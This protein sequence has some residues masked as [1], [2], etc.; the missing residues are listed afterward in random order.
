VL[1]SFG[2]FGRNAGSKSASRKKSSPRDRDRDRFDEHEH[3]ALHSADEYDDND[4]GGSRQ[5]PIGEFSAEGRTRSYSTL[6]PSYRSMTPDLHRASGP[7]PAM[8]RRMTLPSKTADHYASALFDFAG[9]AADELPLYEGQIVLVKTQ[10]SNDW[11]IGESEG[12]TGLFPRSYT[13]EYIPTPSTA[14][15]RGPPRPARQR[16]LPPLGSAP[17]RRALPPG[18]DGL[19]ASTSDPLALP[20]RESPVL[21]NGII[22][23]AAF[24]HETMSDS[25]LSVFD[26]GDHFLTVSLASAPAPDPILRSSGK[27]PPPPPPV[28]RRSQSSSNILSALAPPVPP[29]RSRASTITRLRNPSPAEEG[30]P[31]AASEDEGDTFEHS[32][33]AHSD[34]GHSLRSNPSELSLV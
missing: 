21:V 14:S 7:S 10:V 26:D 13:E 12:K 22:Q 17:A 1:S 27:K 5:S 11:W 33:A 9:G 3:R 31:F 32:F 19:S 15:N 25:E 4:D 6:T 18:A 24:N 29:T 23:P 8:P 34:S 16:S 30:S 28:S 2:S 20:R